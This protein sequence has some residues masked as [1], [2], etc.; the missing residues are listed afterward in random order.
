MRPRP[1]R[2]ILKSGESQNP[3]KAIRR[4]ILFE[5]LENRQL[6]AIDSF[7]ALELPSGTV[8]SV[9]RETLYSREFQANLN[10]LPNVPKAEG[11]SQPDAALYGSLMFDFGTNTSTV[12][13]DAIQVS[14][15]MKYTPERG[16]GW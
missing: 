13:P 6:M 7:T 14:D 11:E 16:F 2:S 4:R 9:V 12:D 1:D 10:Y 5:P 3:T 8:P 15:T